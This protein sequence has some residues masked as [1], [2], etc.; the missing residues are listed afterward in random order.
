M[1]T[2]EPREDPDIFEISFIPNKNPNSEKVKSVPAAPLV[3][4]PPIL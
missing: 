3:T 1:S 2:S 4:F